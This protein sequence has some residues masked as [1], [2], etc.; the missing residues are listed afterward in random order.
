MIRFFLDWS[1]SLSSLLTLGY[2][3]CLSSYIFLVFSKL[4]EFF[5]RLHLL[6]WMFFRLNFRSNVEVVACIIS[7]CQ[8]PFSKML[9]KSVKKWRS[10]WRNFWVFNFSGSLI[11]FGEVGQTRQLF[12]ILKKIDAGFRETIDFDVTEKRTFDDSF[13]WTWISI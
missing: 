8:F 11:D 13:P 2:W 4:I 10:V 5:K 12:V 6:F 3:W 1:F 7:T 9:L